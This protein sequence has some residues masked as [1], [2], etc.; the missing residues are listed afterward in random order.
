MLACN[1]RGGKT[2][3]QHKLTTIEKCTTVESLLLLHRLYISAAFVSSDLFNRNGQSALL[4]PIRLSL[5][6]CLFI[7][8]YNVRAATRLHR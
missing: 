6:A 5:N 4:E 1:I 7:Y 8:V 2:K 3:E